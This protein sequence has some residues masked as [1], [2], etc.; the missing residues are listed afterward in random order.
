[1][2][3][4][5]SDVDAL[6]A[7]G[8]ALLDHPSPGEALSTWL[9]LVALHATAMRGLVATQMLSQPADGARTALAACHDAISSTGAALLARAQRY[10]AASA[11]ADIDDLL[12]LV[13]AAA[14]ASE[15]APADETLLERL[16]AFITGR[17]P[18]AARPST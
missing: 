2:A 8:G 5:G 15:Q 11:E 14:W 16:L 4:I 18:S 7:S 10:G 6:C 3:I 9:H 17:L 1:M 12:T 13:N